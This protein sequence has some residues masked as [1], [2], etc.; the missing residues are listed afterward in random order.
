MTRRWWLLGAAGLA[1][2]VRYPEPYRPPMQRRPVEIGGAERLSH[3]IAM[4]A[5]DAGRHIV[6][7]VLGLNDDTW[8]WCLRRA[9]FQFEL[10]DN[11]HKRLLAELTVP[12][13]TFKQTGPVK[14][15]VSV[16]PRILETL[17]FPKHEQRT[18][19]KPVPPEWITPGA[20][21]LV[22]LE[23]DKLWRSPDD[24]AERGFIL[25]RLGFIE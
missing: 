1:G 6:E 17:D 10:P 24:G 12:E 20:P 4:N 16:G 18:F 8:R 23:I 11:R 5:P 15:T 13:L 7:G 22:S 2:C 3:F 14:I 25:T 9:V 21:I 19:E